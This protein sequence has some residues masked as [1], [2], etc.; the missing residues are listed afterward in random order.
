[1]SFDYRDKGQITVG[2]LAALLKDLP[3]DALVWH[4]GCDCFGA[5]NGVEYNAKD[6]TVMIGRCN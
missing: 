1:M 6:N 5:A 2:E 4:E 3:Q